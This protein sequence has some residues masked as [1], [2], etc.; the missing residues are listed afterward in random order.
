MYKHSIAE[1]E[2]Q[3]IYQNRWPS[4][5]LWTPNDTLS[6]AIVRCKHRLKD[7]NIQHFGR[8]IPWTKKKM[9]DLDTDVTTPKIITL[10]LF[11][12]QNDRTKMWYNGVEWIQI[13][14]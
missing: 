11:S 4:I 2:T 9:A 12:H 8:T 7:Q 1:T 13:S 6:R 5:Q 3:A 14:H 10:Y